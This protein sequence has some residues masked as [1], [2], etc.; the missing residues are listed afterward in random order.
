M[1]RKCKKLLTCLASL[2]SPSVF[3]SQQRLSSLSSRMGCTFSRTVSPDWRIISTISS[4]LLFST[5]RPFISTSL[6]PGTSPSA[7]SLVPAPGSAKWTTRLYTP[8]SALRSSMVVR[9]REKPKSPVLRRRSSSSRI[10]GALGATTAGSWSCAGKVLPTTSGMQ[11]FLVAG[12]PVC[13]CCLL[14][15]LRSMLKTLFSTCGDGAAE[16]CPDGVEHSEGLSSLLLCEK[17]KR[18]IIWPTCV[19]FCLSSE[20]N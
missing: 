20:Q 13:F 8:P 2:R 19:E 17:E 3:L 5:F 14:L 4:R 18:F 11:L 9:R 1:C 15:C 10:S 7:R 12:P 6:S 16:F